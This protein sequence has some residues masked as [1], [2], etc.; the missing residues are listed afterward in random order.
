M[1]IPFSET[2]SLSG[3]IYFEPLPIPSDDMNYVKARN[4][5]E[6]VKKEMDENIAKIYGKQK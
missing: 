1:N 3:G 5:L 4:E 6:E 2:I